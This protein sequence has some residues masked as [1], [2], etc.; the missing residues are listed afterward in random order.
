MSIKHRI[1]Q[2]EKLH[3]AVCRHG[4]QVSN[5]VRCFCA[6]Q[7]RWKA[8]Y[9]AEE[10]SRIPAR[11][12]LECWLDTKVCSHPDNWPP[13]IK[14]LCDMPDEQRNEGMTRIVRAWA[15]LAVMTHQR[16]P[17]WGACSDRFKNLASI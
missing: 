5:Q 10:I 6:D 7:L 9:S 3:T 17:E 2:V 14:A 15:A 13:A 1:G 8:G 11:S 12:L 16:H 4:E